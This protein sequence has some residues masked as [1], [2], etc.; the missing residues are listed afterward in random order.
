MCVC[1]CTKK[2]KDKEKQTNKDRY[3]LDIISL[4]GH[5]STGGDVAAWPSD[6]ATMTTKLG[7]SWQA[8]H[9][10][11]HSRMYRSYNQGFLSVPGLHGVQTALTA[12]AAYPLCIAP[13]YCYLQRYPGAPEMFLRMF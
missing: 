3:S 7:F 6:V 13:G 12:L 9:T 4:C 11:L 8:G 2:E 1:V 10:I 5:Q